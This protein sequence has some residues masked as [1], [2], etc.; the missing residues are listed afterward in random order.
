MRGTSRRR[1]RRARTASVAVGAYP[2]RRP[3]RRRFPLWCARTRHR[4]Q[5]GT[6]SYRHEKPMPSTCSSDSSG[7]RMDAHHHS[8][9]E[10]AGFIRRGADHRPIF[11]KNRVRFERHMACRS[12]VQALCASLGLLHQDRYPLPRRSEPK[13][14][15]WSS[16]DR[17]RTFFSS[18]NGMW[19]A[20]RWIAI[21]ARRSCSDSMP[22]RNGWIW[23]WAA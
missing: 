14:E 19:I 20:R 4:R 11:H 2:P 16:S 13:R 7:N 22:R 3:S 15:P 21:D 6:K 9:L 8:H 1:R 10:P 23:T 12:A 5:A 17:S 18:C